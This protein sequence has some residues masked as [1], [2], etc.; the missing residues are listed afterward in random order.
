MSLKL[1]NDV[2]E[3]LKH[4]LSG[5]EKLCNQ[6]MWKGLMSATHGKRELRKSGCFL[7]C[8]QFM[9]LKPGNNGG[10]SWCASIFSWCYFV[11]LWN[12]ATRPESLEALMLN[13]ISWGEDCLM[14]NECVS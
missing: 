8:K 5:Y 9:C 13:G 7:L 6:L 14:I 12:L 11:L 3:E 10:G 4:M 1:A 2:D